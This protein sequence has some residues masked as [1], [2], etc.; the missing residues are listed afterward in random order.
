MAAI[1]DEC[2]DSGILAVRI[3]NTCGEAPST[4]LKQISNLEPGEIVKKEDT[5]TRRSRG[6][7]ELGGGTRPQTCWEQAPV[8]LLAALA[9]TVFTK[10]TAPRMDFLVL[11]HFSLAPHRCPPFYLPCSR[12]HHHVSSHVLKYADRLEL[13]RPMKRLLQEG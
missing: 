6:Q 8:L 3:T 12:S 13:T 7:S 9:T 2:G 4:H 11:A 1:E 10:D 5:A